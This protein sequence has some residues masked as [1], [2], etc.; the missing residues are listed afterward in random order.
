MKR[1][2]GE[3]RKGLTYSIHK[4]SLIYKI[5]ESKIYNFTLNLSGFIT[6]VFKETNKF[7]LKIAI[8]FIGSYDKQI[9][10]IQCLC[11]LKD[12]EK[13][14]NYNLLIVSLFAVLLLIQ[15]AVTQ[16]SQSTSSCS[17]GFFFSERTIFQGLLSVVFAQ[18]YKWSK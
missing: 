6:T 13:S 16:I 7:L 5:D 8:C 18:N 1:K 3:L 15:S 14:E 17:N 12:K 11:F 10:S 4:G 9:T 2:V